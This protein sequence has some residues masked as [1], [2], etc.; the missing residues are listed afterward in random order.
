MATPLLTCPTTPRI[1]GSSQKLLATAFPVSGSALSS[2]ATAVT[3]APATPPASLPSSTASSTACFISTPKPAEVVV[4]GPP[5]PILTFFPPSCAAAGAATATG[6]TSNETS[7][8]RAPR[9][10]VMVTSKYHLAGTSC[11]A[12]CNQSTADR[13]L[14]IPCPPDAETLKV[15]RVMAGRAPAARLLTRFDGYT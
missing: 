3:L 7:K 5:T 8:G 9:R 12:H 1:A 4:S 11:H 13:G 2:T 10:P 14:Q 15:E 6:R